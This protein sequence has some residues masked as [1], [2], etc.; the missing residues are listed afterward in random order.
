MLNLHFS[1]S[2][3]VA[4]AL[5]KGRAVITLVVLIVTSDVPLV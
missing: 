4:G 2:T 1:Y 5:A 3:G